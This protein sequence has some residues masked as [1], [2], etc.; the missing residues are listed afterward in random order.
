MNR[1]IR[2]LLLF[3]G[4]IV[5]LYA[6]L[7]L[8][9]VIRHL[10]VPNE[11]LWKLHLTPFTI[12][13]VVWVFIFYISDLYNLSHAINNSRFYYR[14]FRSFIIGGLISTIFFYVAPNIKIEPKTNLV[15]FVILFAI[16][17][18][19]WRN[20][21]NW[22]LKAY[23][24]KEKLAFIG[25]NNNVEN[26][27][28]ELK[29]KSH[30]GFEFKFI[31]ITKSLEKL[32]QL[33]GIS[34]YTVE[35]EISE[36][37]GKHEIT[38]LILAGEAENSEK[39]TSKLFDCLPLKLNFINL[40]H[41]YEIVTGKVPI[42]IISKNWFL[43]NLSE[44]N[45]TIYEFF[46]RILDVLFASIFFI[47]FLPFWII[48]FIIIKIESK[49]KVFFRQIREG[50]S[51]TRFTIIKFRTMRIS[52]N[53]DPTE[54]NDSR[55]TKFGSFLRKT[56]LDETPQIINVLKGEMSF[57]GPRPERPELVKRLEKDIHF[58]NERMLVK[59]GITGWNQISSE[60][61]SPSLEDTLEK[62][63]YDLFYIKNRTFLLDISIIMKTI[64]TIF[65]RKGR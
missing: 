3:L 62:L 53:F 32:P 34:V 1:K 54:I 19:L 22:S 45:K 43:E 6:T 26:I 13:F 10:R 15:I 38:T 61:H 33:E 25:F 52:N 56:R 31:Y 9:L 41:F 55:I 30:L 16:I 49:G 29:N 12:I 39:L 63:Q 60:Y 48:I 11:S 47:I 5:L 40:S 8:T 28:K 14:S 58:Y 65:A 35:S 21:F 18:F 27:I 50:K 37:I 23:I 57:V 20:F 17:F 24:P 51:K 7:Y 44:G 64:S 46:K 2:K 42:K 36:L 59:P 4:D